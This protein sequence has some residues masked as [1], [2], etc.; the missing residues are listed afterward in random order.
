M[1]S[2]DI[3]KVS[4]AELEKIAKSVYEAGA[5]LEGKGELGGWVGGKV[6]LVPTDRPIKDW[7]PI[8]EREL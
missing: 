1:F 3:P 5:N 4:E 7:A 8:A 2:H 6:V